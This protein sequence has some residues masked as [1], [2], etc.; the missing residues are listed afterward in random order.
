MPRFKYHYKTIN[1]H[2]GSGM[3]SSFAY[4]EDHLNTKPPLLC[5]LGFVWVQPPI[6]S[7]LH[8]FQALFGSTGGSITNREFS[9]DF[10]CQLK[11]Q[12]VKSPSDQS[13][14]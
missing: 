2:A 10:V 11:E 14:D 6:A 12:L 1:P 3:A 5:P 4:N 9:L 7:T 8:F 13:N